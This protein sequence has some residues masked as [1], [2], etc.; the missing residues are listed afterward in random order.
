M[1]RIRGCENMNILRK[2]KARRDSR[3]D[4]LASISLRNREIISKIFLIYA[5]FLEKIV[6]HSS[7]PKKSKLV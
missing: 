1:R 4:D 5:Y 7:L 6:A 3:R 2:E